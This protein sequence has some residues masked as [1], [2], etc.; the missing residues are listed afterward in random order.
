MNAS[1]H[2]PESRLDNELEQRARQLYRQAAQQLDRHTADRLREARRVALWS[3]AAPHSRVIRWLIPTGALAVLALASVIPWQTLQH[4]H[5]PLSIQVNGTSSAD[6]E[7][8]LP[9]DAD[10]ADPNLYQNLAFYG[11]L[12]A[13]NKPAM[14]RP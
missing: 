7:S 11:W 12:A 1:D 6:L 9:P 3:R 4:G 13:S 10:Q 8:D 2:R 5:A 14:H